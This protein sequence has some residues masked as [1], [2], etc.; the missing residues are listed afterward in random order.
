MA[1]ALVLTRQP[2]EF[3]TYNTGLKKDKPEKMQFIVE[4]GRFGTLVLFKAD[5]ITEAQL[6]NGDEQGPTSATV[7][8]GRLLIAY[9]GQL[10]EV[11]RYTTIERFD[12]NMVSM[13]RKREPYFVTWESNNSKVRELGPTQGH[14]FRVNGGHTQAQIGILIQA[15]PHVGWLTG[16]ISPRKLG[17]KA[18]NTD[19]TY[20]AIADMYSHIGN[21]QANLF[22]TDS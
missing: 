6:L 20:P 5:Q 10:K 3:F 15:A 12:H 9:S 2:T 4:T 11:A 22:I 18:L 13:P 16:C 8:G 7:P 17:D 19:S 14:C 21:E 1:Y